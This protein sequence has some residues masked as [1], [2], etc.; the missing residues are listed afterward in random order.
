MR[1]GL[2][3]EDRRREPPRDP[4]RFTGLAGPDQCR[5]RPDSRP[6]RFPAILVVRVSVL[7]RPVPRC[8]GQPDAARSHRR[9]LG[10]GAARTL[11]GGGATRAVECR[12]VRPTVV[13]PSPAVSLDR[14]GLAAVAEETL[15]AQRAV[16]PGARRA[17]L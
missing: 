1:T 5:C 16:L 15:V 17:V 11:D 7:P 13:R 9:P 14:L 10:T 4:D 8:P 6:R 3:P 2:E 12:V